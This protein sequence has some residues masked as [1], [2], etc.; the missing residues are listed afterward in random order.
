MNLGARRLARDQQARGGRG[1]EDRTRAERQVRG[2][3][4]ARADFGREAREL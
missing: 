3:D 2:A 1:T 4:V